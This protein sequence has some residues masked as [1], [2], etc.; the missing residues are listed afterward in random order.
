MECHADTINALNTL[1][2]Y[3]YSG[4]PVERSDFKCHGIITAM[5]ADTDQLREKGLGDRLSLEKNS[6]MLFFFDQPATYGFWMKDMN[7][8]ID[9]IWVDGQKKVVGVAPAVPTSTY[10][11]IFSPPSA[12]SFVLE[13]NSG[14]AA[15]FGIVT[16]I[17]LTW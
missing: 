10:P 16:G 11:S 3:G 12:I 13:V 7:F 6:G 9:I 14:S 1:L 15:R 17:R 4:S 8:P 2:K 5:V